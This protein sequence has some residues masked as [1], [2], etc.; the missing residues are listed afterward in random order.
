MTSTGLIV[1]AFAALVVLAYIAWTTRRA[2]AGSQTAAPDQGRG[3]LDEPA[4][5]IEDVA[6]LFLSTG[7]QRER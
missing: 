3:L 2:R 4:T 5:A 7:S 1:G 6:D